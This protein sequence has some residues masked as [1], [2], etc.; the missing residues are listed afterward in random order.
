MTIAQR[1]F[2]HGIT[3]TRLK[4]LA[5]VHHVEVQEVIL[6][7]AQ[8]AHINGEVPDVAAAYQDCCAAFGLEAPKTEPVNARPSSITALDLAFVIDDPCGIEQIELAEAV[9]EL[10]GDR[11]DPQQCRE[12]ACFLRVM[13]QHY[14]RGE[15][16]QNAPQKDS[17]NQR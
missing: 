13:N 15:P 2:G 5:A 12:L 14:L 7:A 3:L 1:L 9:L 11:R 10:I 16:C 17:N 6:S 8:E 4:E